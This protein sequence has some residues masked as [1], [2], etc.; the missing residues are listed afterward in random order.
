LAS[1]SLGLEPWLAEQ[2]SLTLDVHWVPWIEVHPTTAATAELADGTMVWVV[3]PHG[4]YKA[5][6]KIFRGAAP[7][8][9]HAPYGPRHP[10]GALANPF[11]L[12]ADTTDP[13]TGLVAW[14]ATF[15]RLE[16]A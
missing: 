2:P 3:T 5:R 14:D 16:R 8:H 12:L 9:V 13:L 1:G 15:V 6:L 7:G 4:R 10:D 11:Q